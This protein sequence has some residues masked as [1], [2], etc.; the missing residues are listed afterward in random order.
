LHARELS[1]IHPVSQE[2]IHLVAPTPA[3]SLWQALAPAE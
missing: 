3:D 1:F 2:P